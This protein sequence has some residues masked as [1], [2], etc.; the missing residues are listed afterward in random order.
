MIRPDDRPDSAPRPPERRGLAAL[1]GA[2]MEE[3]NI[4]WGELVGG[5][6]VI[7]CT[8][9]LVIS[10][11][12]ILSDNPL[13]KFIPFTGSAAAFFGAGLYTFPRW[14]LDPTSRWLIHMAL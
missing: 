1:F 13:F 11:S 2:F 12:H 6:L 7:G 10:L 4:L 5:L 9:A 3:H 8:T 14:T